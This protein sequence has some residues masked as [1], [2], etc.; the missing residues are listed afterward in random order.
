MIAEKKY[1]YPRNFLLFSEIPYINLVKNKL[2][3]QKKIPEVGY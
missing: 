2:F 1:R 3:Y